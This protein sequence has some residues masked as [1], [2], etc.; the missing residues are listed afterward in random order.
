MLLDLRH[1]NPEDERADALL[2]HAASEAADMLGGEITDLDRWER[3]AIKA[4]KAGRSALVRFESAVIPSEEQERIRAALGGAETVDEV[5]A[6]FKA[7]DDI[8][9]QWDAATEWAKQVVG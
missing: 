2:A 9:E 4:V 1:I 6:A 3:K 7:V 5:K 8:D